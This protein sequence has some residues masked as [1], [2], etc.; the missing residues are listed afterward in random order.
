MPVSRPHQLKIALDWD[1]LESEVSG[2]VKCWSHRPAVRFTAVE[3]KSSEALDY[4]AWSLQSSDRRRLGFE[5]LKA[6][7][8]IQISGLWLL[9]LLSTHSGDTSLLEY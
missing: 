6:N 9:T 8:P 4:L 5:S 7:L 2:S 3:S 1:R